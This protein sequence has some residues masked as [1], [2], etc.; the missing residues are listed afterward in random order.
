MFR[1]DDVLQVKDTED[2]KEIIRRHWFTLAPSL[3]LAFVLIVAPFFLMV[4][5]FAWGGVGIL[6][7]LLSVVT[8]VGIAMRTFI[9]WDADVLIMTTLRLVD[10][11]QRG[12]FTRIVSETPLTSIQD[13]SWIR[14]G[15]LETLFRM[16]AV[17]V[18]TT[19]AHALLETLSIANP[20]RVHEMINDLRHHTTPK[21]NDVAPER[22]EKLRKISALLEGFSIE[23]L[24]RVES[25][26]R[27]RERTAASDAFLAQDE[28]LKA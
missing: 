20:E 17:R 27:A 6:F 9:L 22:Q 26:L 23:E 1:L 18:Q 21:R 19:G 3:F 8:G 5:L 16:G 15:V 12:L 11:D 7:F 28:S 10:V 24:T 13:V 4:Q 25:V 14:K 2:V